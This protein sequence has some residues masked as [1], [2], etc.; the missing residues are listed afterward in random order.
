MAT[1][2]EKKCFI[3]YVSFSRISGLKGHEKIMTSS[4]VCRW[5]HKVTISEGCEL[6]LFFKICERF[7]HSSYTHEEITQDSVDTK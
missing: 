3:S 1:K 4:L 2:V 6:T 7:E 5:D